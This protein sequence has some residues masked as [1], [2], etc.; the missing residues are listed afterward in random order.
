MWDHVTRSNVDMCH[1]CWKLPPQSPHLSAV[2]CRLTAQAFICTDC[3][4]S[5]GAEVQCVVCVCVCVSAHTAHS[6]SI[7]NRDADDYNWLATTWY[8]V[9]QWRKCQ[10]FFTP[11]SSLPYPHFI[12]C[13]INRLKAELNPSRHFLTLLRNSKGKTVPLRAGRGPECSRKLRFPDFV[14]TE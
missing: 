2:P 13:H 12:Q 9:S 8:F 3:M 7:W 10:H 1:C 11:D 4:Q 14:T 6:I 5:D